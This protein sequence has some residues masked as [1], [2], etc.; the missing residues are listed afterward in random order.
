MTKT[1]QVLRA[2]SAWTGRAGGI[3]AA[4]EI[5][6]TAGRIAWVGRQGQRP[7][8]EGAQVVDLGSR[9]FLPGFIDAHLHLW[10]LDLADATGLWTWPLPYRAMRAAADMRRLL[11]S[12][13]TA[14]RCMGGPLGP[15]LAKAVREGHVAGPHVVAAGEFICSRAGTWDHAIW[16]RDWVDQLG[17]FAD[18]IDECRKRVR[19]RIRE[20]ADLIKIGGS[21]GEHTDTLRQWGNDPAKLRLSYSDGE[22]AVLVEE[23]H[24]NGLPVATHA[25]GEAAVRQA[26]EAGVDSIEHGH[27]IGE[28]T[29]RMLAGSGAALVPTLSLPALRAKSA[30]PPV[31]AHWQRHRDVQ[32]ASLQLALKHGARIVAGTDFVGPP[33]TPLGPDAMEMEL[34]AEAGMSAE[35]ALIAGT[36][37]AAALLGLETGALEPGLSADILALDGDPLARIGAVREVAFV[38]KSGV[39]YRE[40]PA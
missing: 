21:V 31:A 28:E 22:V 36:S 29:A 37:G 38:M 16:P 40:P 17:M 12:G 9:H 18:G 33:F 4:P 10:G 14:V 25:I 32:I 23:A 11:E 1:T 8:P 6:V 5:H 35:Q 39:V 19:E 13:I 20:G 24:R 34:L 3:L 30:P 27:G 7:L 26:L 15:V 2:A